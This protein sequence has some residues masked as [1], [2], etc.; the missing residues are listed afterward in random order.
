MPEERGP[1][2]AEGSS[3]P[4]GASRSQVQA[5]PP[6]SRRERCPD[7]NESSRSNTLKLLSEYH[8]LPSGRAAPR[9]A[10]GGRHR[11]SDGPV[12]RQMPN[13]SV[14]R[15]RTLV[16]IARSAAVVGSIGIDSRTRRALPGARNERP[17]PGLATRARTA[18]STESE[19]TSD[20]F[21]TQP[22][23]PLWA[24]RAGRSPFRS[25]RPRRGPF[26]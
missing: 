24:A 26:W 6:R 11:G 16:R 7:S 9:G 4:G 18:T 17:P 3:G 21:L 14:G 19:V 15:T 2:R 1:D 13:R 20:P 25:S 22:G 8:W 23:K 10:S 12:L 5:R